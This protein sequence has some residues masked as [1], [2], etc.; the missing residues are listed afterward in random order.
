MFDFRERFRLSR[1]ELT[2]SPAFST[3]ENGV[4]GSELLPKVSELLL[5]R[6]YKIVGP[7]CFLKDPCLSPDSY[8]IRRFVSSM[9]ILGTSAA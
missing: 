8:D 3:Y 1:A 4:A 7:L 6:R 5:S 9:E 2:S